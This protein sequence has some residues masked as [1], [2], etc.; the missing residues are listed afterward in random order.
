MELQYLSNHRIETFLQCQKKLEFYLNSP[1]SN[2]LEVVLEDTVA[3]SLGKV[4][5]EALEWYFDKDQKDKTADKL[6]EL[7]DKAAKNASLKWKTFA[8]GRSILLSWLS[9]SKDLLERDVI[10]VEKE[11]RLE[12]D[13]IPLVGVLD[14]VDRIDDHTIDISDYKSGIVPMSKWEVD[15]SLQL[16]IYNLAAR[17]MW[18]W[19]RKVRTILDFLRWGRMSTEMTDGKLASLRAYLKVIWDRVKACDKPI[20]SVSGACRWCDFRFKCQSYNKFVDED[21]FIVPSMKLESGKD[22]VALGSLLRELDICKDRLDAY[23]TRKGEIEAWMRTEMVAKEIEGFEHGEW[24][25][26]LATQR[27]TY[28]SYTALKKIF[29]PLGLMEEVTSI[30]K[31][32][33]DRLL[34]EIEITPEQEQDIVTSST[35]SYTSPSLSVKR[36]RGRKTKH[37]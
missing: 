25:V 2:E 5:H 1:I 37:F 16:G 12:I 27:R 26:E 4:L 17:Q 18:P 10:G 7:Y 22:N 8:D 21:K 35:S 13:G 20:A 11:F 24:M 29:E 6:I 28:Y 31:G 33:V 3:R 30:R 23:D 14:R 36:K 19:V 15:H 32:E 9:R 34:K